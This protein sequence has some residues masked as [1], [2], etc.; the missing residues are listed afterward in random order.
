MRRVEEAAGV[1]VNLDLIDAIT[2][3]SMAALETGGAE[4][5]NKTPFLGTWGHLSNAASLSITIK[6]MY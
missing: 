2:V 3:N 1:K 4:T 5:R 6:A